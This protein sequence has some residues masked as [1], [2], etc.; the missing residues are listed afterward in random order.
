AQ[1]FD[2]LGYR[3]VY[4]LFATSDHFALSVNDQYTPAAHFLGNHEVKRNPAHV[5]Y[6]VNPTMDFSG[7]GT[8]ADHAYWLSGLK[9]RNAGGDAP[10]GHVD[11][12]SAAFGHGDPTAG[13]TQTD[14]GVLTGGN[15]VAMPYVER[16][17]TWGKAPHT[18][19]R[20]TLHLD[21]QNLSR[22]VV[23]PGRARLTCHAKLDVSTDG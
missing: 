11:A 3:Y 15:Y 21:V 5:S 12:R 19:P 9:L 6:V 22:V 18:D 10:L 17:K 7:A 4:D 14:G 8:V 1:T 13:S 20:D 16:S 2:D 23:H